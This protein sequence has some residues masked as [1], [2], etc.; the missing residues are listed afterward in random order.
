[1][2]TNEKVIAR[3]TV[4]GAGEMSKDDRQEIANWLRRKAGELVK[5]G[6]KYSKRYTA[7]YVKF[8]QAVKV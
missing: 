6:A 4:Y 1:M 5:E 7:R 3:V 8:L 2:T